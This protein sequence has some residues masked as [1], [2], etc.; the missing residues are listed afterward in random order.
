MKNVIDIVI[1]ILIGFALGAFYYQSLWFT[2]TKMFKVKHGGIIY[3][4]AYLLRTIIVLTV[5]YLAGA[6]NWH[7][8][9][10]MLVGFIMVRIVNV[11]QVQ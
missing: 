1:Y 3:A 7:H 4:I 11:R 2:L 8:M 6:S 9:V 5:F 10:F